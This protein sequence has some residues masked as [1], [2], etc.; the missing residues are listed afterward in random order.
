VIVETDENLPQGAV[1]QVLDSQGRLI[2]RQNV[3]GNQTEINLSS[4]PAGM[5]LLRLVVQGRTNEW[6]LIKL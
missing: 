1:I 4:Q 6:R 3:N 2:N 5:Y